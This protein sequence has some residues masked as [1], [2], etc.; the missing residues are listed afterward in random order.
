MTNH[1]IAHLL[2]AQIPRFRTH[3]TVVV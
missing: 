2:T 1:G 3:H